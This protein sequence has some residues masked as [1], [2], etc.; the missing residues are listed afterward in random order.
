MLCYI[1]RSTELYYALLYSIR[2]TALY[3]LYFVLYYTLLHSATLRSTTFY[4]TTA[5]HHFVQL[6]T[7]PYA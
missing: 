3:T 1:L 5:L 2:S 4:I 7:A 6:S